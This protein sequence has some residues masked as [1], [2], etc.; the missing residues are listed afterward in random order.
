MGEEAGD[1]K[2]SDFSVFLR[3][4]MRI[5]QVKKKRFSARKMAHGKK[6]GRQKST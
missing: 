4:L 2:I 6:G 5:D 1:N 3:E